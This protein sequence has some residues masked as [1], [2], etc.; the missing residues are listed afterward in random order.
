MQTKCIN[1]RSILSPSHQIRSGSTSLTYIQCKELYSLTHNRHTHLL[2]LYSTVVDGYTYKNYLQSPATLKIGTAFVLECRVA[3]LP[4]HT[5]IHYNWTYP[6][7][8][9]SIRWY[10]NIEV[11]EYSRLRVTV[12]DEGDEGEYVCMVTV[13]ESGKM[14]KSQFQLNVEGT[15]NC[16]VIK[17]CTYAHTEY[18]S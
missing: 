18:C 3:G 17:V 14:I 1:L 4:Y 15:Y 16:T 7:S 10:H 8:H 13:P 11:M 12:V 2:C 5:L 9:Q 6:R